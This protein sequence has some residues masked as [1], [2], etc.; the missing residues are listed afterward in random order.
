MIKIAVDMMGSDN[1]PAELSKGVISFLNDKEYDDVSLVL[2][3]KKE[4]LAQFENN[5]RVEIVDAREILPMEAGALEAV[6]MKEASMTK[7]VSLVK[8]RNLDA[9]VSAG[10]TGGFISLATIKMRLIDGVERAA[11]VTPFPTRTGKLMTI[12]DIGANNEN[13]AQHLVQ[14]ASMGRIYTRIVMDNENP[15]VYLLSNGAE[16]KKGAPEVKEAHK[17]LKEMNF[18]GFKGNIEGRDVF[19]GEVDVLVT[20]GYAGNVFLKTAEGAAGMMK[21]LI[22]QS[23]TKN[24]FTK[25]GYIFSKRG[26]NDMSK[27]MDYRSIGGAMLLGIN[28]VAVKGHG[29]SDAYSFYNA[30][31]LAVKMVRKDVVNKIKEE[32][33]KNEKL[34]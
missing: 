24:L 14:F 8:E 9:V 5:P 28:G 25:I 17:L 6:R 22:K 2:V 34:S 21:Y 29:S 19:K 18:E 3:G 31:K 30:I 12:L 15:N 33:S 1:G 11:L 26:F 20:G 10:G 27:I 7:A 13:N 16:D 4:K 32:V 23:F